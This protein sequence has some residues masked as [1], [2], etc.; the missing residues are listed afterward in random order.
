MRIITI[1]ALALLL[2]PAANAVLIDAGDITQD[3][4]TGLEWLDLTESAGF[5]VDDVLAGAGGFLADGWSIAHVADVDQLFINAGW[6]GVDQTFSPGS[7]AN[8]GLVSTLLSLLGETQND[9]TGI[10][11]FGE[12]FALTDI[13]GD[14]ARPFFSLSETVSG[15]GRI[16][17]ASAGHAALPSNGTADF[18]RCG[19]PTDS[20]FDFIGIYLYRD[21]TAVP[22]PD[23]LALLLVGMAAAG[24]ARRKR[25]A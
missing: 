11:I 21:I 18:G 16:A 17:C 7:A 12:G 15:F 13:A 8:A 9:G 6:D 10:N 4:D 20:A 3:T 2:S 14:V 5:S 25:K 19:F 1:A 23:V 24:V 22:E